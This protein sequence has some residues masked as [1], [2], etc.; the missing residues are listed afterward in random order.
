VTTTID[1]PQHSLA[2]Y[3]QQEVQAAIWKHG[4]GKDA[5][6]RRSDTQGQ[7]STFA[8]VFRNGH[9]VAFAFPRCCVCH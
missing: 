9:T 3:Q 5:T 6:L 8:L 7:P 1:I 2:W 4:P